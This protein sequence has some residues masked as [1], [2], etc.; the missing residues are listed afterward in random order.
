MSIK[1]AVVAALLTVKRTNTTSSTTLKLNIAMLSFKII[2][3]AVMATLAAT[4]NAIFCD[5]DCTCSE[6]VSCNV[7][8]RPSA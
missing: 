2:S 5:G 6:K 3:L 1:R 8:R 4:G 7:I